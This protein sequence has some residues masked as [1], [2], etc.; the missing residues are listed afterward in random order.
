MRGEIRDVPVAFVNAIRRTAMSELPVV[1]IANVQI[2]DNKSKM[3]H[4]VLRHRMEMFP[5]AV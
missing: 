1:T 5:I 3:P 4:E 2:L